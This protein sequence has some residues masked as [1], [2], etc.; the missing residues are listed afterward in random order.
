M[1]NGVEMIN[2]YDCDCK[3]VCFPLFFEPFPVESQT[4]HDTM[5][6]KI[7]NISIK[8]LVSLVN[9]GKVNS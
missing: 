5:Q 1:V 3:L 6:V 9:S 2:K 8:F 4:R 7:A